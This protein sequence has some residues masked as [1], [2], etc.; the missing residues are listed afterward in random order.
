MR[1]MSPFKKKTQA[2]SSEPPDLQ[3]VE[4]FH[5]EQYCE[6][7]EGVYRLLVQEEN[8]DDETVSRVISY[9]ISEN[10]QYESYNFQ[11]RKQLE[12]RI[13]NRFRR[14]DILQPLIDDKEITEVMVNGP[15]EIF[16]ER[17]GKLYVSPLRFKDDEELLNFIVS[18]FARYN[19]IL[20][21]NQPM[22]S[23][24]L[25]DG[26]RAHAVIPPVS[27][28]HPVLTVRKFT[29][30]RPSLDFLIANEFVTDTAANYLIQA[31]REKQ[32]IMIGGGTGSGKTTLLNILSAFI[33]S[34]ERIITIEDSPELQL[35][36]RTNWV[37][38]CTRDANPDGTGEV[39]SSELIR[40]ALRMRPDRIIVGEVRGSE[41]YDMLQATMTGHPG[42]LCTVHGNDCESMFLRTADLILAHSKM[43]Y[44]VIIRQLAS[45]FQ[46][47]VHIKRT[48]DG[49]RYISEIAQLKTD[50][51]NLFQINTLKELV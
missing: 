17:Q 33:P 8:L 14:L 10:K 48:H 39:T 30:L 23:L 26:S 15:N 25:E 34:E 18:Y 44:E 49:K 41:A 21:Q 4:S 7:C 19:S 28:P 13:F 16:Y 31:V 11:Q 29:G 2:I 1:I 3:S 38:L 12:K 32:A 6:L 51:Q 20:S 42:T 43:R 27:I 47:L 22:N 35:Q 37:R 50:K 24:R 5:E 46:L 9:V 40:N 45:A 36:R